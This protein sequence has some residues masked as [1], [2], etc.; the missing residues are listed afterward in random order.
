M[1]ELGRRPRLASEALAQVRLAGQIVFDELDRDGPIEFRVAREVHGA[2]AAGA[3][4][5]HDLITIDGGGYGR[6][7]T[8]SPGRLATPERSRR[9]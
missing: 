4:K 1:P 7:V 6:H 5:A 9:R 2:H 8:R 3:Q